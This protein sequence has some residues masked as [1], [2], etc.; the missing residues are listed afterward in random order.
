[1]IGASAKSRTIA[2]DEWF[3]GEL[4]GP[5][6]IHRAW[7]ACRGRSIVAYDGMSHPGFSKSH[8]L[9]ERTTP[10]DH[11][12]ARSKEPDLVNCGEKTVGEVSLRAQLEHGSRQEM[13][14]EDAFANG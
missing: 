4:G 1:M 14:G 12:P 9:L 10:Y 2:A 11:R 5:L 8:A 7:S 6:P 3:T 13:S